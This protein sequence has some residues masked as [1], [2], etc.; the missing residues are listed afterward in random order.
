MGHDIFTTINYY[1][2]PG[3]GS[4][5]A[6]VYVGRYLDTRITLEAIFSK[7]TALLSYANSHR[8]KYSSHKRAA[9]DPTPHDRERRLRPRKQLHP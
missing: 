6:P 8:L 2:D 5:P 7:S 1:D 4:P 3:D 9:D